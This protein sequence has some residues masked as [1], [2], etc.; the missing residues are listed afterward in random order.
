MK[1]PLDPLS[2]NEIAATAA[3]L[4]RDRDVDPPRWRFGCIELREPSKAALASGDT[5]RVGARPRTA[6]IATTARPTRRVVSLDE[7][8]VLS[9]EHRPGEQAELHRRRVPRGRRDA[10]QGS[11]RARGARAATACTDLDLVLFD[12]WAYGAHL[13]AE[14]LPGRRVGWTDVWYRNPETANPYANPVSG[15]HLRRR[16][17][18]D[19]AAGHRGRSSASS[20]RGRWASTCPRLVPGQ[21]LRERPAAA[22]D[23]PARRACRSRSRDSYLEWQRW[24]MRARLQPARGARRLHTVGYEDGGRVRPVAHRMS[25]A[26][27]VVPYRDPTADHMRRT[28]FDIGEWGL[29][30]MTTSLELG[31]D[32]LGEITY[33]DAV[34]HDSQGRAATRS[35]TRSASTRRTTPCSGS[36]STRRRA[37]RCAA[38]AGSW[39]PSTRRSPTT[40]TSCTGASTRTATSSA[41]CA[42]PASWSRPTSPRDSRRPY[43]TLVDERTYAPFHQHFIV[44]R[45]DLDVDGERT[46]CT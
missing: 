16:R 9:W 12:T 15:L 39:S 45:L 20:G 36:T 34:V 22:R 42:P 30:F 44:A 21:Q 17:Q 23:R 28:A 37:P 6:G 25:F 1:H 4:R 38:R 29:G 18:H 32:C 10:A 31:C 8:S 35:R 5:P 33:L 27:M 19:G 24:S 13:V 46:R 7:D 40:S 3:I 43:G 14:A 41:R 26:E 11:A 2:A